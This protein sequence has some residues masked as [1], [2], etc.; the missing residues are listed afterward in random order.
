MND[1]SQGPQSRIETD[2]IGS[3]GHSSI[4]SESNDDPKTG[5]QITKFPSGATGSDVKHTAHSSTKARGSTKL[6]GKQ[7]KHVDGSV[8][9]KK[10]RSRKKDSQS[11]TVVCDE[12]NNRSNIINDNVLLDMGDEPEDSMINMDGLTNDD[13][14]R[15]SEYDFVYDYTEGARDM[16][17]IDFDLPFSGSQ[18]QIERPDKHSAQDSAAAKHRKRD[19][20]Y[21]QISTTAKRKTCDIS[22]DN[23]RSSNYVASQS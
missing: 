20:E 23:S 21:E 9:R 7:L 1:K 18:S 22:D 15:G 17:F 11:H 2:N 12:P 14:E 10:S 19:Y 3:H 4:L 5:G 8:N 16:D 6:K 13:I